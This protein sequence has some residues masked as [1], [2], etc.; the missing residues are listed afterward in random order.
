MGTGQQWKSWI[1]IEDEVRAIHHLVS[2]KNARGSYN[3]TAPN[4]VMQKEF[5][6]I[7]EISNNQIILLRVP[8]FLLRLI[9]GEMANELLLQGL[10]VVPQKLLDSSFR[11]QYETLS[12]VMTEVYLCQRTIK[13]ILS[14]KT[15]IILTLY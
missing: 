7:P 15:N 4:P 9:K 13:P 6:I 11:F 5:V 8:S 12:K 10:K 3:L 14:L 1:H 2:Q